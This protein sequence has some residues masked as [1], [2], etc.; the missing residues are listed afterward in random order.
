M[1]TVEAHREVLLHLLVSYWSSTEFDSAN[2]YSFASAVG[3]PTIHI[4]TR[5]A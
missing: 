3:S 1:Y 2:A 5:C 4:H